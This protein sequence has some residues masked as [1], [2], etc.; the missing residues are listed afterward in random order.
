MLPKT[1]P[2]DLSTDSEPDAGETGLKDEQVPFNHLG[3]WKTSSTEKE[4]GGL[5]RPEE[6]ESES[7]EAENH[8]VPASKTE[9]NKESLSG[10]LLSN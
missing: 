3:R 9:G 1:Y 10:H 7:E 6:E 2:W 5:A 8:E 4:A